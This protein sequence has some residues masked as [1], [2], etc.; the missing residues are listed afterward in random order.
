MN[1]TSV[2]YDGRSLSYFIKVAELENM[3]KAAK[4]LYVSQ[5][6][7]TRVIK[8]LEDQFEVSFF[9]RVGKRIRLNAT[10]RTFYRYAQ[11]ILDLSST[12]QKRVKEVYLHEISQITIISNC[13]SY[14]PSVLTE[15]NDSVPG[16][17]FRQMSVS[18][19]KCISFLK[20]GVT[21]FSLCCPMIEDTEIKS[22]LLRKEPCILIYPE[23]HWLEGRTHVSLQEL[24][25][26]RF[27]GQSQGYATRDACDIILAKYRFEP[28]YIIEMSETFL[29]SR[30]VENKLGIAIVPRSVFI[31]D[32]KFKYRHV[33][34]DEPVY[35]NVGLSWMNS[36]S[37]SANDELYIDVITSYFAGL[38]NT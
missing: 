35:G 33:E 28:N 29:I 14:M 37:L 6:Q 3:T 20:E 22:I 30:M 21:D 17:K 16:L 24:A 34:I 32:A 31:N 1:R 27:V 23:G 10:G 8:D 26:E 15:L 12:A 38:K 18:H 4:Q 5:A 36:R 25:N 11:Q 7:L 13:S 9:D 2:N 19:K